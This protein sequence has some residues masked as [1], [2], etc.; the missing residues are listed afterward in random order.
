[1]ALALLLVLAGVA[2]A[3]ALDPVTGTVTMC[4]TD[5]FD[6]YRFRTLGSFAERDMLTLA[7]VGPFIAAGL[8]VAPACGRGLNALALG[9]EQAAALGARLGVVRVASLVA[10]ALLCGAATAA[11]GPVGFVG[12]VVPY[13]LRVLVGGGSG[14]DRFIVLDR[15]LPRA[16]AAWLA[17]AGVRP[18]RRRLVMLAHGVLLVAVVVAVTGPIGFLALAAPQQSGS[19]DS[20]LATIGIA[21]V[22]AIVFGGV[23]YYILCSCASNVA[24]A[25]EADA[26]LD[27]DSFEL[28]YSDDS[29]LYTTVSRRT[30]EK[31]K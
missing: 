15:R 4:D 1:M 11:A 6:S 18:A 30:K 29:F 16:I 3:A 23:V 31:K 26:Y 28:T 7:W 10:I 22:C 19:D 20:G 25:T 8:V 12:L 2:L 21:L 14:A 24:S 17:G 13:V 27:R 9:D 5:V